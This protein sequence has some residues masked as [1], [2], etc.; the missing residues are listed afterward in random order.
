[1]IKVS[2]LRVTVLLAIMLVFLELSALAE[3]DK[4]KA[5]SA[6]PPEVLEVY[7]SSG[8]PAPFIQ[9]V[10]IAADGRV[11]LGPLGEAKECKRV[12]TQTELTELQNALGA[13]REVLF[14]AWSTWGNQAGGD[15]ADVTFLLP[16][17]PEVGAGKEISVPF[18]LYPIRLLPLAKRVDALVAQACDEESWGIVRRVNN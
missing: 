17:P 4:E 3:P 2:R 10:S 6:A 11:R 15:M 13:A 7:L 9:M 14:L 8:G 18:E 12:V 1:M 16:T 5:G